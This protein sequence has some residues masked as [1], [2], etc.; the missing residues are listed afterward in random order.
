MQEHHS[1]P[2][3]LDAYTK[4]S[5]A[6]AARVAGI[7]AVLSIAGT[8]I[9]AIAVFIKPQAATVAKEGF[10]SNP[11]LAPTAGASVFSVIFSLLING[12]LFFYLYRFSKTS[13]QALISDQSNL[14]ASG[15]ASLAS[16]FRICAII[17]VISMFFIFIAGLAVG[18]GAGLQ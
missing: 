5:I 1:T 4:S 13:R 10:E 6:G 12:V 15:L 9:S 18:M 14:L 7:A 11:M 3:V 17:I 8:I 16:Y 2:Q